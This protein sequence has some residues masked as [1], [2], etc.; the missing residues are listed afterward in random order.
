VFFGGGIIKMK[1]IPDLSKLYKDKYSEILYNNDHKGTGK[2][3]EKSGG[4]V[5]A[6]CMRQSHKLIEKRFDQN[7][8]FQNIIEIGGGLAYHLQFINCKYNKY[9]ITDNDDA[10]FRK[11]KAMHLPNNIEVQKEDGSALSFGNNVFDRLIATNVLEHIVHPEKAL[12]EWSRIV[13]NGGIISIVLPCD[14]GIAW[15]L[16]RSIL[17]RQKA[18]KAGITDWMMVV[19]LEHVNAIDKLI[20][21]IRYFW[22]DIDE[23]F[24]PFII[25]SIDIN[26][27][28]IVHIIN[29]K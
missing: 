8:F 27:F 2:L 29:T 21:M 11:L 6:F 22:D 24:W 13:K 12:Q 19:A 18:K 15:R 28:Y 16:G 14:P 25:P 26:L 17:S 7:I 10:V 5:I 3:H 4:G 20:S 1:E 9:L 23:Y